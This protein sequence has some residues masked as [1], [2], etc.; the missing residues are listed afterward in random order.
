MS[1]Y[2]K[3]NERAE[4]IPTGEKAERNPVPIEQMKGTNLKEVNPKDV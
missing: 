2:D 1:F 3:Q 4:Y